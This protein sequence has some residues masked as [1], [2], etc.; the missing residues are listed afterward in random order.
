MQLIRSISNSRG[1]AVMLYPL[2]LVIGISMLKD[3]YEDLKR[4]QMD[5]EENDRPTLVWK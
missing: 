2:G 4:H 1:K 3:L 5:K